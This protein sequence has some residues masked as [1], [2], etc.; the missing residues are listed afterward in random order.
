MNKSR[1]SIALF[2]LTDCECNLTIN[3]HWLDLLEATFNIGSGLY[4]S[5]SAVKLYH[6]KVEKLPPLYTLVFLYF[7]CWFLFKWWFICTVISRSCSRYFL[8]SLSGNTF[9]TRLFHFHLNKSRLK[10]FKRKMYC[11]PIRYFLIYSVF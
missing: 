9:E 10:L 7:L 8:K 2:K 5:S 4:V 3:V 6:F 1:V 11:S